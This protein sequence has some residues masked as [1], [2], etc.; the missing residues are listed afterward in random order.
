M[1]KIFF[2]AGALTLIIA[3]GTALPGF[4][5][6]AFYGHMIMHMLVVAV[7]APLIALGVRGT[8]FDPTFRFENF[9]APIPAATGELIIV[10]GWHAPYFHYFARNTTLG[11]ILE[12]S[13]FILAGIWVWLACF[14]GRSTNKGAGVIGLLLTSMHMTFLGALLSLSNRPIYNHHHSAGGLS[15]LQDQHI[16]GAIMLIVGGISYLSGGLWL[17]MKILKEK[18]K[19]NEELA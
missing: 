14:S 5:R 2:L 4:S 17:T 15:V 10:W 13:S 1:K 6:H 9:F 16:G 12:Q 8:Q 3:W 19:L 7:A 18:G 11:L